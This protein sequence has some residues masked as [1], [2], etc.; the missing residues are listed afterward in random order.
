[1]DGATLEY[2]GNFNPHSRTGSD[3]LVLDGRQ[4][5]HISIHTPAQGV[6]VGLNAELQHFHISIHTPAQGVTYAD[7]AFLQIGRISIHTPAQGVTRRSGGCR[8]AR[9][10]SI[11]TPAQ[12]VTAPRR[13]FCPEAGHFNPHSRTGSDTAPSFLTT[14][15]RRFQSTLP[16]R[17]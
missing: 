17:E 12:G 5:L 2:K 16:H 15:S 8:S 10:I 9:S 1:M 14:H 4:I 13:R 7:Q 6:T 11:H 3:A